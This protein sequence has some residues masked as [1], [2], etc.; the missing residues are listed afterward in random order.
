MIDWSGDDTTTPTT[1]TTQ[2]HKKVGYFNYRYFCNFLWFVEFGMIYGMIVSYEPFQNS[3]GPLYKLQVQEFRRTGEWKH[4]YSMVP[5]NPERLPI[6]LAFMLCLAVGIAVACLGLFHLYLCLSAQTTI[7]FHG[8]F[9]NRRKAQRF[10]KKWINPYDL[11]WKRNFQQIY[12]SR[13]PFWMAIGIPSKR[14]PE[15]LP[16]PLP[17]DAGKRSNYQYTSSSSG[18]TLGLKTERMVR[19]HPTTTTTTS[20]MQSLNGAE[21]V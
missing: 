20:Q 11:G 5:T 18:S 1:T 16:L 9:M 4:L 10:K 15:F 6:S 19:V 2:K 13:Q 12:G 14:E 3:T 7:E 17:G 21:I 8:N